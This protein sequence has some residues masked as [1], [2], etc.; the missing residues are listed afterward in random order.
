MN[1][2]KDPYCLN[3]YGV[4]NYQMVVFFFMQINTNMSTKS[5]PGILK[6]SL[7]T[8]VGFSQG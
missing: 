5:P 7:G 4:S 6:N 2:Q 1:K 3:F 8:V